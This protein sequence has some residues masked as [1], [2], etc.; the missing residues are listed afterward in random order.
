MGCI[1]VGVS[2]AEDIGGHGGQLGSTSCPHRG[3]VIF[4]VSPY[5]PSRSSVYRYMYMCVY[6]SEDWGIIWPVIVEHFRLLFQCGLPVNSITVAFSSVFKTPQEVVSYT[7]NLGY[8]CSTY[9]V[10]NRKKS[11]TFILLAVAS[12]ARGVWYTIVR[13]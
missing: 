2:G 7:H 12:A 3:T 6:Y 10:C 8:I 4:K 9:N 11:I 5:S 1:S 13:A